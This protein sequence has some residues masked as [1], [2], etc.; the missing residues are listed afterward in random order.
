MNTRKGLGKG[1]GTGYKNIAPMDA[2][3]HSL[4]AKGQKTYYAMVNLNVWSDD[5]PQDIIN[6][7]QK[8]IIKKTPRD[9]TTIEL[10]DTFYDVPKF[11]DLSY[12][13]PNN[14]KLKKIS[15][16]GDN[17]FSANYI[18]QGKFKNP[19]SFKKELKSAIDSPEISTSDINEIEVFEQ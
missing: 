11:R 15:L 7:F 10:L 14:K 8:K 2:H 3:I 17:H 4:S 6:Y 9:F 1:L 19:S 16:D 5:K 12:L 13:N 18:F